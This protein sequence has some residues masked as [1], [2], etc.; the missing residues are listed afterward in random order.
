MTNIIELARECPGTI[1]AVRAEDLVEANTRLINK[2][3][4]DLE[5]EIAEKRAITYLTRDAV[6]EK[7]SVAPST[8]WRWQKSGYLVP[9]KVGG[10]NRYRSTDIDKILEGEI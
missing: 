7:L 8:L 4:L 9:V 6:L 2:V 3:R 1:I 5:R 10:E